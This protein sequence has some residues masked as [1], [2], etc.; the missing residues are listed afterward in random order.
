MTLLETP[1]LPC[2]MPCVGLVCPNPI[3]LAWRA[4][5]PHGLAGVFPQTHPVEYTRQRIKRR[6]EPP[7]VCGSHQPIFSIKEGRFHHQPCM[8]LLFPPSAVVWLQDFPP[9]RLQH[10][11]VVITDNPPLPFRHQVFPVADHRVHYHIEDGG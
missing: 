5:R 1:Y 6:M 11:A 7:R 3:C 4:H 8:P 9:L 2:H 10:V